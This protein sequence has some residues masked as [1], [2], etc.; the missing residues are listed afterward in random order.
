MTTAIVPA[1]RGL[2]TGVWRVTALGGLG[3]ALFGII[4]LQ[5]S[6]HLPG[7]LG[8]GSDDLLT[9]FVWLG[10][11]AGALFLICCRLVLT[12]P[13][14]RAAIWMILAVAVLLRVIPILSPSFLSTDLY[15]YVWDGRVQDAGI[16]PYRYIPSAR[17]LVPLRDPVIYPNINRSDYAPTIYPPAA[18][19]VFAAISAVS[20]TT[21]AVKVVMTGFEI[22]AVLAMMRLLQLARRPVTHVLVYAWNPIFAW[23]YAG[24]GHVDAAAIGCIA[25]ALLAVATRRAGWA[26]VAIAAATLVKFLPVVLFPALWRDRRVR[27]ALIFAASIV[28]AYACYASV[29]LKVF[30]F[31]G[32][33][34]N[35]EGLGSGYGIF[36]VHLIDSAVPLPQWAGT[37]WMAGVAVLLGAVAI[38]MVWFRPQ[39]LDEPARVRRIG[40]DALLL[41]TITTV[42]LTPH[43]AWYFGWI[44]FL[45]CLAPWRCVLWLTAVCLALY[46]DPIHTNLLRTSAI[47]G[48]F[49]I[50]AILDWRRSRRMRE[51][52]PQ[53]S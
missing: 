42:G 5:D 19:A 35:E 30:G 29:G 40:A 26:G 4:A 10:L 36:F 7:E 16:N 11:V 50:L 32:G 12:R 9:A 41:A 25:L 49:L 2:T 52:E 22:V 43:Y 15:R 33:Y 21:R 27:M 3:L 37:A 14:P 17:E 28:A 34:A 46:L 48:P 8:I 47:Y 24:N 6:L 51:F 53:L 44:G 45:A 20:P 23:E 1:T 31:L 38:R 13:M 18:Q 39:P